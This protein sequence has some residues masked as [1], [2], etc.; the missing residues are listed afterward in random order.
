MIFI[1][2]LMFCWSEFWHT[3]KHHF[4]L[5]A[6]A[7]GEEAMS[8]IEELQEETHGAIYACWL[9]FLADQMLVC[10]FVFLT[11]WLIAKTP[12]VELFP[13]VIQPSEAM[14]VPNGPH[15][16]Q[17]Y[18][19][20]ALDICTI[21]FFAI[22]FYFGLMF[23]VAHEM[24]TLTTKMETLEK[25]SSRGNGMG[26]TASLAEHKTWKQKIAHHSMGSIVDTEHHYE[27]VVSNFVTVMNK[28]MVTHTSDQDLKEVSR[29]V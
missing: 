2:F 6:V 18:R 7:P 23:S 15:A 10:I 8:S 21:F 22:V 19:T 16:V 3:A 14:H 20:L 29:L 4:N 12:M 9:H 11:L 26:H 28:Q 1:S 27:R 5:W 17:E 13:F 25:A 24:T